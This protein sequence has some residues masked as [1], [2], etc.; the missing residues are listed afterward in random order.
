MRSAAAA[1][2]PRSGNPAATAGIAMVSCGR[3][4]HLPPPVADAGGDQA[5]GQQGQCARLGTAA[6]PAAGEAVTP[7]ATPAVAVGSKMNVPPAPTVKLAP[8]GMAVAS[9]RSAYRQRR[10]CRRCSRRCR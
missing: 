9:S 4:V 10:S 1:A 7:A 2:D 5:R 8:V 6:T 3:L